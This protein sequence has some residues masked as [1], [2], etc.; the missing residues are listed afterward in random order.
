MIVSQ[1]GN[2]F[3]QMCTCSCLTGIHTNTQHNG[4]VVYTITSIR[5]IQR[6]ILFGAAMAEGT[7][8]LPKQTLLQ[9]KDLYLQPDRCN[10]KC[11]L[12][13]CYP[14]DGSVVGVRR[15]MILEVVWLTLLRFCWW[16]RRGNR[17]TGWVE[18][19]FFKE[20][21]GGGEQQIP[22]ISVDISSVFVVHNESKIFAF[23]MPVTSSF[24]LKWRHVWLYIF[25]GIV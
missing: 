11:G 16:R 2:L 24:V 4:H 14:C 10:G 9:L 6:G 22:H 19:C 5:S 25:L 21:T 7:K 15:L 20:I 3:S 23:G 13:G 12:R 17:T 18:L 1:E 8:L